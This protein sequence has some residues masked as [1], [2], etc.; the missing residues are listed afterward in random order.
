MAPI[1]VALNGAG[2]IGAL[3]ALVRW[4]ERAVALP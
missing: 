1:K 3:T 4:K 2:R